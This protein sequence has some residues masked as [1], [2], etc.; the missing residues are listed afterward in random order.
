MSRTQFLGVGTFAKSPNVTAQTRKNMYLES[1][2]A[3]D[4]TRIVAFPTPGLDLFTTFGD[5]PIRAIYE[6]G[7]KLYVVHRTG[8][9]EVDNAGTLTQKGTL[10]TL[11]GRCSIIDNGV[12]IMIVDG[13]Y[14]YIYTLA[15]ETFAQISDGDFSSSP[16]TVT[17]NGG[18]FIITED[19]SGKIW[20]SSSYD[21]TAWDALD[22]ATAESSPDNLVRVEEYIGHIILFGEDTTEFWVNTGELGFPYSRQYG[23]NMEY[24]L[25][26]RWSV[27]KLDSSIMFL[28]RSRLGEVKVVKLTGTSAVPVSTRS[29][30]NIFNSGVS[31]SNATAFSYMVDGHSMYQISFPVINRTFVYDNLTEVWHELTSDYGRHRGEI[32]EQFINSQIVSDY[33][34]GK[35]YKLNK[36]TYTDNGSA[37]IRELTGRHFET[38][39]DYFT[40]EQ[41]ILDCETGAGLSSGQGSDPQIMMQYSVDNGHTWSEELQ[42]SLGKIGEYTDRVEWWRLGRGKDFLFRVRCSDPVKWVVTGAGLKIGRQRR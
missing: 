42:R 18:Y 36:D 22:F 2:P 7:D 41:F 27:T 19:N 21:G 17:F 30:E 33:D 9:Y 37:I 16:R 15:T 11:E 32:G 25:A 20:I 14:G 26:A 5:D 23:T 38:D 3:D 13:Q 8:F 12:Q 31:L 39:M 24:G 6:V 35:I 40:I 1:Y 4:K 28:G 34:N 29:L 10:L